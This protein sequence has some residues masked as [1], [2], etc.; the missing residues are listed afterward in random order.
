M[1]ESLSVEDSADYDLVR[2]AILKSYELVPEAQT[3]VE[4]LRW[5][6]TNIN[7]WNTAVNVENEK[8]KQLILIEEFK[9]CIARFI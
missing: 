9:N 6:E 3:Y 4:F 8:L 5:K 7:Q 2:S 1:Y